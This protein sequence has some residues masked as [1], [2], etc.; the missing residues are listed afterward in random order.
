[1]TFFAKQLVTQTREVF[2]VN[3]IYPTISSVW[4]Y[5]KNVVY[6]KKHTLSLNKHASL[7]QEYLEQLCLKGVPLRFTI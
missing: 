6:I 5:F 3:I 7:S 2:Y 1:M 4:T